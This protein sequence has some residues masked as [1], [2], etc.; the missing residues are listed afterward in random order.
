MNAKD[1]RERLKGVPGDYEVVVPGSDHS[2][3]PVDFA[4]A[5]S[6]GKFK[7]G[8][9]VEW[10]CAETANEGETETKVFVIG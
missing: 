4:T 2:Y 3:S 1:L 8:T 10:C 9:L 7:N 5:E 6:A